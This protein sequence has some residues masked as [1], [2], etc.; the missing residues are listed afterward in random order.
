MTA[1][2]ERICAY[3]QLTVQPTQWRVVQSYC[4]IAPSFVWASPYI[5]VFVKLGINYRLIQYL[6]NSQLTPSYLAGGIFAN[7]TITVQEYV[8]AAPLNYAWKSGDFRSLAGLLKHLQSLQALR[9]YVSA[10]YNESYRD[11]LTRSLRCSKAFCQHSY[12]QDMAYRKEIEDLLEQAECSLSHIQGSGLVPS[13]GDIH[14]GNVLVTPTS[15]YLVDWETFHLSDPLHDLADML[16]WMCPATQWEEILTLFQVDL[17][18]PQQRNRFYFQVLTSALQKSLWCA[19]LQQAFLARRYLTD[20][21]LA[22]RQTPPNEFVP[23]HPEFPPA[24]E[25]RSYENFVRDHFLL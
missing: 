5:K 2:E 8:Q 4:T 10:S 14:H 22:A 7:T 1:L 15:M 6:A 19:H 21:H 9:R 24:N 25:A 17:T 11:L 16:W 13:H 23:V 12:I 18:N 20:A 3:L